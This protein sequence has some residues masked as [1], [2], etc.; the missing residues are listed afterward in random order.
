MN[1]FPGSDN[2]GQYLNAAVRDD[3]I[4]IH[5]C[6]CAGAGLENVDNK[7]VVEFAVNNLLGSADNRPAYFF[8]EEAQVHIGA[9][10]CQF[11]QAEGTNEFARKSKAAD[12]KVFDGALRLCAVQRA[13]GNTHF[14]HRIAFD[15]ATSVFSTGRVHI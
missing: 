14:A 5:I 15:A 3:L 13:R 10:G 11:D 6:G 7:M 8:V 12:G 4:R 9:R 1:G 2:P